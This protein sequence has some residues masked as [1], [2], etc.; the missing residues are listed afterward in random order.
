MAKTAVTPFT[1]QQFDTDR[2]ELEIRL[3]NDGA[4]NGTA[5]F[6]QLVLWGSTFEIAHAGW[7][8]IT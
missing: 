2:L 4:G 7:A 1:L 5:R 6:G 8:T 3:K